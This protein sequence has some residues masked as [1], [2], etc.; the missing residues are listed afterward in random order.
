MKHKRWSK[1]ETEYLQDIWGEMSIKNISKKL[2][3]TINSI[4]CRS[5]KLGLTD[6]RNCSEY[7]TIC[8][9]SDAI[10]VNYKTI[11]C[12]WIKKGLP[13]K[14]KIFTEI[15]KV[16][17][18]KIDDFWKWAGKNI[19]IL[20]F[21]KF[22]KGTLGKEPNWVSEKRKADQLNPDKICHNRKWTKQE[23]AE[24]V[25]MLKAY[26]YT[27]KDVSRRIGRT[28]GAIR[29]RIADLKLLWRP[30]RL[31]NKLWENDETQKLIILYR[32]GYGVDLI[33]DEI[34][35]T[36]QQVRGKIERI[37]KGVQDND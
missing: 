12:T 33:A 10:G 35:R 18:I 14:S 19:R 21:A 16:K 1:E 17:V 9:L 4:K 8:K 28:E 3:R 25:G 31:D 30:L 24:L 23:D 22:E 37:L 27:Y 7:I 11:G 36:G 6:I 20:N 34:G 13:Y 15:E 2:G 29:R 5:Q 26:K 32:K